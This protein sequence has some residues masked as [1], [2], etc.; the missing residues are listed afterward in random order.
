MTR[1]E[2]RVRDRYTFSLT[3]IPV[4]SSYASMPV[5]PNDRIRKIPKVGPKGPQAAQG[6]TPDTP[7]EVN[8]LPAGCA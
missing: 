5:I 3:G 8:A 4:V 2:L 1:N 6:H 7:A